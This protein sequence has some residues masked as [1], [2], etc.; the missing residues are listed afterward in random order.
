MVVFTCQKCNSTLKKNAVEKHNSCRPF[1]LTCIDCLKDF[2]GKEYD[3]HKSCITEREKYGGSNVVVKP[4]GVKQEKWAEIATETLAKISHNNRYRKICLA[5][6][7][8]TNI[9]RNKKKFHNF[10][11]NICPRLYETDIIDEIFDHLMV[12][13]K[14]KKETVEEKE[15]NNKESILDS[16][17][18]CE[19]IETINLDESISPETNINKKKKKKK[20]RTSNETQL[21]N[22]E[23]TEVCENIKNESEQQTVPRNESDIKKCVNVRKL[24]KKALAKAKGDLKLSLKTWFNIEDNENADPQNKENEEN[25][26]VGEIDQKKSYE[27]QIYNHSF[28][29]PNPNNADANGKLS[30]KELKKLKKQKKYKAEIAEIEN[31]QPE[32]E[33]TGIAQEEQP[34]K[35]KEKLNNSEEKVEVVCS[36][37]PKRKLSDDEPFKVVEDIGG[38]RIKLNE[39]L[40]EEEVPNGG[41]KKF[42]WGKEIKRILE[43]S[44]DKEMSLKKLRKKVISEYTVNGEGNGVPYEQLLGIFNKKVNSTVG[45]KVIKDR[46]QLIVD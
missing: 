46:A 25:K 13:K 12:A 17:G 1:L 36:T 33:N 34:R 4:Q 14:N 38:K 9:P 15:I 16:N 21:G 19:E 41:R 43:N 40:V 3:E 39:T 30:K 35:K 29:E 26:A 27:K 45:I 2:R 20:E 44:S 8:S 32:N 31:Y 7:S 22:I 18:T 6:K 28:A 42:K 11:K 5:L 24:R 10:V 37:S 23:N